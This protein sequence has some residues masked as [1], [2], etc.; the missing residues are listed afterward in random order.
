MSNPKFGVTVDTKSSNASNFD[1]GGFK[2]V[3][4]T[5]VKFEEVGSKGIKY[6]TVGFYFLDHEGIKSFKHSEFL[7]DD[8][9]KDFE[10]KLNGMNT[11]IKHIY[12]AFAVFPES[13]IGTDAKDFEDFFNKVAIAFNTGGPGGTP[14]YKKDNISILV[15]IKLTYYGEKTD[16]SF[17]LSPNFIERIGS[18]SKGNVIDNSKHPK[19]LTIN[20][21]YDKIEQPKPG[22]NNSGGV[23]GGGGAGGIHT[24][25]AND[26]D[27]F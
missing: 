5:D 23:M 24:G 25:T 22:A 3:I 2:K 1:S 7:I 19:V 4:L 16:A 18:D 11:R 15:Y 8:N 17:P 14:I 20:N 10:K 21:K 26:G 9:D 6:K 12:E 27:N 13:G